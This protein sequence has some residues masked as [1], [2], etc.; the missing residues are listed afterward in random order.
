MDS[1]CYVVMEYLYVDG[2]IGRISFPKKNTLVYYITMPP[3]AFIQLL[4]QLT[5]YHK[6]WSWTSPEHDTF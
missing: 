2:S 5:D 1:E 3:L 4:N 6:I